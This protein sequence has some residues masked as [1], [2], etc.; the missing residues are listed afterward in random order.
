MSPV[1]SRRIKA[2]KPTECSSSNDTELNT[3]AVVPPFQ[4]VGILRLRSAHGEQR[5]GRELG[6]PRESLGEREGGVA[7]GVVWAGGRE[8]D[9]DRRVEGC[10]E[11]GPRV[12]SEGRRARAGVTH[13]RLRHR[14]AGAGTRERQRWWGAKREAGHGRGQSR[15][16]R[17]KEG[18]TPGA[19][20]EPGGQ[21]GAI[22]PF[23]TKRALRTSRG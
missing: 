15:Q 14:W 5:M 11:A 9:I 21:A 13:R 19:G 6:L 8:E 20:A 10:N 3:L 4:R 17:S 7:G 22:G 2:T 16:R 18:Q 1:L 23:T 12:P